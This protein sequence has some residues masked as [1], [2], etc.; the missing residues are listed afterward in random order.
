MAERRLDE[1]IAAVGPLD[2]G[3]M[4]AARSRQAQLTK[5]PGALGRLEQVSIQI[6]GITGML[7]P[8]RL[9]CGSLW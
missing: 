6:A 4:A 9:T 1:W 8:P 7:R 2:E 3:A 5:P